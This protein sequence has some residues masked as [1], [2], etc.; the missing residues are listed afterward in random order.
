MKVFYFDVETSGLDPVRNDILTLSGLIE[1]DGEIVDTIDLKMQ[2]FDYNSISKEALEV[3]GLKLE[4]IKT[5]DEPL[6][7]KKK[8]EKFFCKYVNRFKKNKTSEDKLIPAGYNVLF[9]IRF[10]EEFWKKCG[11]SYFGAFIDYHKLDIA[12]IVLYV[13]Y[14]GLLQ[15]HGYK[16]TQIAEALNCVFKGEAHTAQADILMTRDIGNKLLEV[17]QVKK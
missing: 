3:N 2:P 5:F 16:L 4:E 7:A 9:D 1:I 12:A 11:D 14:K 10:L 13:K 17:I 6:I 15:F 8:L